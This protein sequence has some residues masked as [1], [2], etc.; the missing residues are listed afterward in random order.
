MFIKNVKSN[1]FL[2]KI[3]LT[4]FV[5]LEYEKS[6]LPKMFKIPFMY[7]YLGIILGKLILLIKKRFLANIAPQVAKFIFLVTDSKYQ[8]TFNFFRKRPK[9]KKR[10]ENAYNLM[11]WILMQKYI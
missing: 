2:K 1:V 8:R 7:I 3:L 9:K 6:M 5:L 10:K 4:D 11:G